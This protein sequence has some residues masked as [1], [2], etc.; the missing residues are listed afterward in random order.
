MHARFSTTK[1]ATAALA[2]WL[3]AAPAAAQSTQ[4]AEFQ[5][6][7]IPG[8]SFTPGVAVGVL[9]DSNVALTT[10]GAT[11]DT[12]SDSVFNIVPS[13][14]LQYLGRR[15]DFSTGYRGFLRRYAEVEGFDN[16]HQRAVVELRRAM[17]RHVSLFATN[18]YA[19]SP[20]TDEEEVDGVPFRRR[21]TRTNR[22]SAGTSARLTKFL[23]LTSRYDMT[24][25]DFD[26]RRE[27]GEIEDLS[28]GALHALRSDLSYQLSERL[29]VGGEYGFRTASLDGG[30]REFGFQDVGGILRYTLGPHTTATAS[31]GLGVLNDR[32]ED[33]TRRGAYVRLNL[34][35]ILEYVTVG[36]A[37]QRQYVPTFGFGGS[38]ASQELRGF[39][40]MPLGRRRMY[41]Q[42]TAAWRR[43]IPFEVSALELDTVWI[44]STF[45][46]AV[47][48]WGQL[49]ALY[50]FTRQDSIV[51]GG[52]ISR[53]R[54]GVQFV[55][56]Q[57]MRIR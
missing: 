43:S 45:G 29:S 55:V 7:R 42:A 47:S 12:P 52:E 28:G 41:T 10:P 34:S 11:T 32:T 38:S 53:H 26:R 19:D 4:S 8:W 35:H 9:H 50:T 2:A 17:T 25:I 13:G 46:Y 20:T 51:T 57:P 18:S 31:A 16:Y 36:G 44:R 15:T 24:W 48:R 49:Q 14:Q 33:V 54:V 1:L 21:G 5:S 56:S 22:F 6:S 3:F 37:F 27:I 40:S 39:V 23:T 30:E